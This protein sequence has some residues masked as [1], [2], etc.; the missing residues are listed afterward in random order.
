MNEIK[1]DEEPKKG[2]YEREEYEQTWKELDK[3]AEDVDKKPEDDEYA[4]MPALIDC[5]HEIGNANKEIDT[6][7]QQIVEVHSRKIKN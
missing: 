3:M 4:D 7:Q 6:N 2:K 1:K 5:S